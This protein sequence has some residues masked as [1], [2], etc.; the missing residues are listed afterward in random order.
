MAYFGLIEDSHIC[1]TGAYGRGTCNGDSGGPL[2]V[3]GIQVN[4]I[5][6][7]FRF[8]NKIVRLNVFQLHYVKDKLLRS[9]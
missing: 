3:N 5:F 6:F 7:N 1:T 9:I 4:M 8:S 2:V